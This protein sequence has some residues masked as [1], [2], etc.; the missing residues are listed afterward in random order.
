MPGL[1]AIRPFA[2]EDANSYCFVPFRFMNKAS[3][4]AKAVCS[5]H[6]FGVCHHDKKVDNITIWSWVSEIG[7][8]NIL[9]IAQG[10]PCK[11]EYR[12]LK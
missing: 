9:E 1:H 7:S 10:S 2:S 11:N 3:S 12:K 5:N 6:D 4:D 8:P